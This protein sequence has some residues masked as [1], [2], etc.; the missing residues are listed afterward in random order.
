MDKSRFKAIYDVAGTSQVTLNCF[1][2]S[3]SEH[4]LV[5][6]TLL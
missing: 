1:Y 6:L 3:S 5:T 4:Q 2:S